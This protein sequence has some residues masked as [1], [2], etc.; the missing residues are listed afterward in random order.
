MTRENKVSKAIVN[1]YQTS[2]WSNVRQDPFGDLTYN[3]LGS[4]NPLPWPEQPS[5]PL[6]LPLSEILEREILEK[7]DIISPTTTQSFNSVVLNKGSLSKTNEAIIFLPSFTA[8]V[9]K[10]PLEPTYLR[11]LHMANIVNMPVIGLNALGTKGSSKFNADQIQAFNIGQ[12]FKSIGNVYLD[13]LANFLPTAIEHL[14]L[15]GISQGGLGILGI[16]AN[17]QDRFSI[18]S[19]ISMESPGY[20]QN[21]PLISVLNY[22]QEGT[23]VQLDQATPFHQELAEAAGFGSTTHDKIHMFQSWVSGLYSDKQA[24]RLYMVEMTKKIAPQLL[25]SSLTNYPNLQAHIFNGIRSTI[26]PTNIVDAGLGNLAE[27]LKQRVRRVTVAGGHG[28]FEHPYTFAT[29]V[30]M[31]LNKIKSQS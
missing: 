27:D 24:I 20:T 7:V 18:D 2:P 14:H 22:L 21:L 19:I 9:Q 4:N 28:A 8:P 15:V 26:C 6:A 30:L 23:K 1:D 16:A 29:H 10:L 25:K 17:A 31:S 3:F 11:L 5:H 13:A 12:G